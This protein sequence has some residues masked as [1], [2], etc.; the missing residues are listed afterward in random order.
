LPAVELLLELGAKPDVTSNIGD[1]A[2]HVAVLRIGCDLKIIAA[3]LPAGGDRTI[4]NKSPDWFDR[5]RGP[6]RPRDRW[7]E[8][9][10]RRSS[11]SDRVAVDG[12]GTA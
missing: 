1:T 8:T 5:R 11:A 3:L 12:N 4:E 6:N 10:G 7:H 9:G 2:L